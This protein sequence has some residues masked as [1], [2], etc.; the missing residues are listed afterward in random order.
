MFRLSL[1]IP[2]KG[3]SHQLADS[4]TEH[5]ESVKSH[6]LS[7]TQE[8][9]R[10]SNLRLDGTSTLQRFTRYKKQHNHIN[11][12]CPLHITRWI[13]FKILLTSI[14]LPSCSIS[15]NWSFNLHVPN[16]RLCSHTVHPSPKPGWNLRGPDYFLRLP[17]IYCSDLPSTFKNYE[18]ININT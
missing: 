13:K 7:I 8:L 15:P 2:G 18:V 5:T 12:L 11:P 4:V 6:I 9:G 10:T 1:V 17:G 14:T 3:S 16:R